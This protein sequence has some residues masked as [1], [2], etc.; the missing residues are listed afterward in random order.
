MARQWKAPNKAIDSDK[1]QPRFARP[2]LARHG[3][4]YVF[5]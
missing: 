5:I 3:T 1:K 2:L 4:R